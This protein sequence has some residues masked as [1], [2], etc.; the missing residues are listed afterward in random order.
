[1]QACEQKLL[2]GYEYACLACGDQR[3]DKA[4]ESACNCPEDCKEAKKTKP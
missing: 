1:M 4:S 3:C 2:G